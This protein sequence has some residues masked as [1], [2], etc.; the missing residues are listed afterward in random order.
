MGGSRKYPY[1]YHGRHLGILKAW[2]VLSKGNGGSLDWNSEGMR[3]FS[4]LDFKRS[5]LAYRFAKGLFKISWKEKAK[6]PEGGLND[7]RIPKA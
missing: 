7:Y 4:V 2:G 1:S 6:I 5:R 3:G